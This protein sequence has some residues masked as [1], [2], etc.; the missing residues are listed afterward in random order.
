[1][2]IR[3]GISKT[4]S[5]PAAAVQQISATDRSRLPADFEISA[6]S[7]PGARNPPFTL[8]RRVGQLYIPNRS[9]S[10]SSSPICVNGCLRERRVGAARPLRSVTMRTRMSAVQRL[11]LSNRR[12]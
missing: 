10:D 5:R 7:D 3:R 8:N 12:G 6:L 2:P 4:R 11:R 1:M 9:V